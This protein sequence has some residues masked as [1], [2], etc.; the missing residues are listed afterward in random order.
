[1]PLCPLSPRDCE[2]K[3]DSLPIRASEKYDSWMH[4]SRCV[5]TVHSLCCYRTAFIY[6]SLCTVAHTFSKANQ[7][8]FSSLGLLL[9]FLSQLESV[10]CC[11][12][13]IESLTVHFVCFNYYIRVCIRLYVCIERILMEAI[14]LSIHKWK[15]HVSEMRNRI[16]I[17]SRFD[18]FT[19]LLIK[20]YICVIS[21]ESEIYLDTCCDLL[22]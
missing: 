20:C 16:L 6:V 18:T 3:A 15:L 10:Q 13:L 14:R 7:N 17:S 11:M 12:L 5:H 4:S 2:G 19:I 22:I 9:R 1:M 21:W 8:I